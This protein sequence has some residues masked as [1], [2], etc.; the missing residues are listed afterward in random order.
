M[1]IA[2]YFGN[3]FP[4]VTNTA[5]DPM[6]SRSLV[7]MLHQLHQLLQLYQLLCQSRQRLLWCTRPKPSSS[8][9][10]QANWRPLG[11]HSCTCKLFK[12]VD[13]GHASFHTHHSLQDTEA[14]AN[15]PDAVHMEDGSIM[16]KTAKGKLETWDEREARLAHNTYVRFSRTFERDLS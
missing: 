4:Q 11:G 12:P 16:F 14:M 2:C 6:S 5:L 9:K 13:Y 3:R 1:A 8:E 15:H 10:T 7:R